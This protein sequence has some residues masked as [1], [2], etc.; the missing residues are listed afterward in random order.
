MGGAQ[1]DQAAHVVGELLGLELELGHQLVEPVRL[2]DFHGKKE[3]HFGNGG[4]FGHGAS[5]PG[6]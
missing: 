6:Q 3:I 1:Q 4:W 5:P 2:H